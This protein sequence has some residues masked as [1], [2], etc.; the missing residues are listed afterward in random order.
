M[1]KLLPEPIAFAGSMIFFSM[2]VVVFALL[3]LEFRLWL[4]NTPQ[5]LNTAVGAFAGTVI[6]LLA[7][8]AAIVY[9]GRLKYGDRETT[10]SGRG[11][12]S[13]R[14]NPRR[15]CCSDTVARLTG[16]KGAGLSL[17]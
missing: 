13:R 16:G 17:E 7:I 6:G 1:K 5:G 14:R 8:A 10:R 2:A 15:N 9:H 11:E 12:S 3:N 4:E